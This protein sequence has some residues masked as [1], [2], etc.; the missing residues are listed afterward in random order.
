MLL[1]RQRQSERI[2]VR[3]AHH[4]HTCTQIMFD[5]RWTASFVSLA[6]CLVFVRTK[7][8]VRPVADATATTIA[9]TATNPMRHDNHVAFLPAPHY[10]HDDTHTSCGTQ[11]SC[12]AIACG[13]HMANNNAKWFGSKARSRLCYLLLFC[14]T[15]TAICQ[16]N[17][18]F[19]RVRFSHIEIAFNSCHQINSS[20]NPVCH[21]RSATKRKLNIKRFLWTKLI[22]VWP[23]ASPRHRVRAPSF[24]LLLLCSICVGRP[25]QKRETEAKC[26]SL[27]RIFA[28]AQSGRRQATRTTV[29]SFQI[30]NYPNNEFAK[31]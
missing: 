11:Q 24:V 10:D 16:L 4:S 27:I 26:L 20:V 25:N 12:K 6:I 7:R 22:I 29:N 9:T 2:A 23:V 31:G 30:W 1:P 21:K 15:T 18:S 17:S 8:R 28:H 5:F 14:I 19:S 13:I 3:C